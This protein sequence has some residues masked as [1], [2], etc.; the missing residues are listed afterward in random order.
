MI[1]YKIEQGT[2]YMGKEVFNEV[3]QLLIGPQETQKSYILVLLWT[4][5]LL[6]IYGSCRITPLVSNDS[7][8]SDLKASGE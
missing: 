4:T 5:I 3:Q 2:Q 8:S 6:I 1:P 7:L